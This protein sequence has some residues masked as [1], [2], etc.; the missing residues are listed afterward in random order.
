MTL[1][2][3]LGGRVVY[4]V[5]ACALFAMSIVALFFN[6]IAGAIGVLLF[7]FAMVNASFRL[8]HPR[9]YATE[10]DDRGFRVYDSLGRLVHDVA[11]SDV[12]HLTVFTGNGLRGP[13]TSQFLAWR[14]EPRQPGHGRQPWASGG[15]NNV[16][17]AYD[18]ALPAAYLG[19]HHMLALFQERAQ[20]AHVARVETA[21]PAIDVRVQP[22]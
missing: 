3:S 2:P 16:G 18:G 12:A 19:I 4:F 8:F 21:R 10:L 22:F 20:R 14:C 15:I 11:W 13:G 7:G 5:G 17:E 1:H 9:S 6:P